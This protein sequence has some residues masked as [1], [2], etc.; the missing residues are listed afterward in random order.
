VIFYRSKN[1]RRRQKFLHRF[2]R[3]GV[4]IA[5]QEAKIAKCIGTDFYPEK[6]RKKIFA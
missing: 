5:A 3:S 2:N 6:W 4:S 1:I